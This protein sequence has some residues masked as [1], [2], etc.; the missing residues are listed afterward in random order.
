MPAQRPRYPSPVVDGNLALESQTAFEVIRS[1]REIIRHEGESLLDLASRLDRSFHAAVELVRQVRGTVVVSGM[2][3]AGLVG[4]KTSATLCSTGT[5]S[6]Y[7]HPAEAIHGDL[8]RLH[9]D[10]LV[11]MLSQSGETEEVVRLLPVL[12]QIGVPMIAV[13]ARQTSTLGK[14]ATVTLELG[15]L[16]E[17]GPNQ[18][19]PSTSTT[20]MIAVGDALAL[21]V[22]HLRGFA[23]QDFARLHPGGSLGLKLAVVDDMMRP[24]NECRV[25]SQTQ[26]VREV[27]VAASR[28]G[29]RSGAIM[30]QD[31]QGRLAGIFTDSD[32][33]RLLEHRQDSVLDESIGS[34]MTATPTSVPLGTPLPSAVDLLA[35]KK[36]SELPVVDHEGRPAGMLDI[37]DVVA[38]LPHEPV[39]PED[40]QDEPSATI[41]FRGGQA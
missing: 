35:E 16:E 5:R 30:L 32:L 29:R 40:A 39:V 38:L 4:Q 14:A 13:T 7:L 15:D 31:D 37:T 17:A 3:K 28:P 24:L 21:V 2:G 26:R 18:L 6:I 19:A 23:P 22:S 25:A 11:I 1:G 9:V 33:A 36:I 41:P 34:V 27:F 20:A 10:D 8:G 12:A